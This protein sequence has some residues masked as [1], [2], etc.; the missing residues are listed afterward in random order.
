M[1][2]QELAHLAVSLGTAIAVELPHATHFLDHVEV[3][4]GDD[5][6]VLVLARD[7]QHVAARIADV[8]R[9]IELAE[10]PGLLRPDAIGRGDE[11]AVRHRVRW[12]LELPEILRET[13]DRGRRVEHDLG[14][15]EAENARALG[16]M[17]VVADVDADAS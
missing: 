16:E 8:A 5:E 6:L 17:A 14:A 3:A 4:I 7:R 1:S 12:L 10:V 15:A 9:A 11:V 2:R 13:L